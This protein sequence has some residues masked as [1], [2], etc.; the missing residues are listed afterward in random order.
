MT[1][2]MSV[3]TM[4]VVIAGLIGMFASGCDGPTIDPFI[5][6][7]HFTLYGFLHEFDNEHFVRVIA[8]RRS[9]EDIPTPTS[10]HAEIDGRVTST[11]L[12]TGAQHVWSHSLVQFED[13][14]YGHVFRAT[15]VVRKGH[16]YELVVER[17]DGV[18]SIAQTTVPNLNDW[19]VAPAEIRDDTTSQTITWMGVGTPDDISISYCAKPVGALRCPSIVVPYGRSGRRIEEGWEVDV[20]LSRDLQFVR[21][22]LGV[23]ET[24]TL[25]LA[26]M[27]MLFT[28][29]DENW[30]LP[31]EPFDAEEFAQPG[32]LTNVEN[33]FGFWGS[34]SRS[35]ASWI[36][37][38]EALAVSGFVPPQ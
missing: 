2:T 8:V 7:R 16:T 18:K 22:Q 26:S 1:T 33:G 9:P 13:G 27:D 20:Q 35:G 30:V 4:M 17:S 37:D 15:F 6:G 36:P 14:R 28:A 24:L 38:A 25:E 12:T 10:P 3:T 5:E 29:L 32:A 34:I 23:D 31:E 11:N 19:Q 21:Q